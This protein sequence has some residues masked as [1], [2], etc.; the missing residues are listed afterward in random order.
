MGDKQLLAHYVVK[1][2]SGSRYARVVHV[3]TGETV[4]RYDV[5]RGNGWADADRHCAALNKER[6]RAVAAL[7]EGE[8]K[9]V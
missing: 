7:S 2:D 8:K 3:P 1:K 4:K 9:D 6:E 5:L